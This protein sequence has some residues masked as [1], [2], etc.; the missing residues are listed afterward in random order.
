MRRR[1][2]VVIAAVVMVPCPAF[3]HTVGGDSGVSFEIELMI[4]GALL[5]AGALAYRARASG[6]AIV[7]GVLLGLGAALVAASFI[8][9]GTGDGNTPPPVSAAVVRVVRP[10]EGATVP[11]RV[12]VTIEARVSGG[13]LASDPSSTEGGHLHVFVDGALQEMLYSA[14]TEVTLSRGRHT[15]IVEYTDSQHRS[16]DPP[17]F[18]SVK[19]SAK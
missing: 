12:P 4:L 2:L 8:T 17:I 9:P 14:S 16:F 13:D 10:N 6:N 18:D 3:A 7:S 5:V 15:I 19:V 1:S 11:A